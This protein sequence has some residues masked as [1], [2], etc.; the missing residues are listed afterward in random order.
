M[1]HYVDGFV[2]PVPTANLKAYQKMAKVA[3]KVWIEH[4]ALAYFEAVGDD[5]TPANMPMVQFPKM[6]KTKPGE[7]V[8][9]AWILY[10]S[11]SHRNSVLKKVMADD[12]L[13]CGDPKTM[14]FDV[15]RMAYGGFK[16]FVEG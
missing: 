16:T 2:L 3:A 13:Q 1:A 12:R 11:K 8:V 9:F 5:L 15:K 10:K 14:P 6:A 4:G 7:T